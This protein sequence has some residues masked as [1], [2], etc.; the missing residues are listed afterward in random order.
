[1][2]VTGLIRR[3]QFILSTEGDIDVIRYDGKPV[4]CVDVIDQLGAVVRTAPQ[5]LNPLKPERLEK[6]AD[7]MRLDNEGHVQGRITEPERKHVAKIRKQQ[8]EARVRRRKEYLE[9]TEKQPYVH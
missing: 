5:G 7:D 2:K 4:L 3:L 1:M 8:R 6:H 9:E